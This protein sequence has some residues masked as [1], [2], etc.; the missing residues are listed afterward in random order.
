MPGTKATGHEHR[1]QDQ[2]DRDDGTRDLLHGL[3]GRLL[4]RQAM[5]DV[6]DHRFDHHDGIVHHDTD[7][8]HQ[9]EHREG[10]D[11]EAE[12]RKHREGRDERNR[13]RQQRDQR[14]PPV[15][16]EEEHHQDDQYHRLEQ[17]V[18]DLA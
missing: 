17:R 1:G 11:R 8:Q 18:G 4:R 2:R 16:Q 7:G 5:L 6:V 9:A 14:R 15:L 3:E 13:H 12:Q 10:V